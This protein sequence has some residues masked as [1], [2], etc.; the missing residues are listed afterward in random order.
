M[1]PRWTL[2]R[3]CWLLSNEINHEVIATNYRAE[4]IVSLHHLDKQMEVRHCTHLVIVKDQCSQLGVSH[5]KHK[6]TSL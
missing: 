2:C 1:F 3:E 4:I 6:I 5:H